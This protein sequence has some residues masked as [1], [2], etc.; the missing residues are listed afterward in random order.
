M[1]AP[2]RPGIIL[3]ATGDLVLRPDHLPEA[4]GG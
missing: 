1:C 2:V 4:D 3:L